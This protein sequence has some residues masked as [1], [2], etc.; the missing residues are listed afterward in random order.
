MAC[1]PRIRLLSIAIVGAC[2][3]A[4]ALSG[5]LGAS[6]AAG[7]SSASSAASSASESLETSSDSAKRVVATLDGRYRLVDL[8]PAPERPG[9]VRLT[10]QA[11]APKGTDDPVRL[12]LPREAVERSGLAPGG[13]V[14]ASRRPYGVEL[15]HADTRRAF[16]LLLDDDWQRELRSLPVSL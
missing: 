8:T 15:A 14:A 13:T 4:P 7:G 16:F 3:A 6:S 11:L 10:L 12:Y 1:P 5:S 9:T 2:A